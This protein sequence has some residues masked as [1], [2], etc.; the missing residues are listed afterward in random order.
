MLFRSDD[1][2]AS[3][4]AGHASAP[5]VNATQAAKSLH[6][7]TARRRCAGDPKMSRAAGD[8]DETPLQTGSDRGIYR[9]LSGGPE[10][11]PPSVCDGRREP[12]SAGP[13]VT[14]SP[15]DPSALCRVSDPDGVQPSAS[16]TDPPTIH[17]IVR[18]PRRLP[19]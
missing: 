17:A 16:R 1:G 12:R 19:P 7:A 6:G 9:P 13:S 10:T 5:T 8:A 3:D 14:R 4:R 2:E 15:F 18:C 11:T